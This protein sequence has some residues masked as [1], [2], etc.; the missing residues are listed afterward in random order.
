MGRC[1]LIQ[2][3]PGRQ[4][5]GKV[6]SS[7]GQAEPY[8]GIAGTARALWPALRQALASPEN[9]GSH[10]GARPRRRR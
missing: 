4:G 8:V 5:L 3:L 1:P 6:I 10:E 7:A 9:P 2:A